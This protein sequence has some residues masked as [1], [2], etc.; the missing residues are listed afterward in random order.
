MPGRTLGENN[1]PKE[2]EPVA[3]RGERLGNVGKKVAPVL[4]VAT[5]VLGVFVLCTKHKKIL[6]MCRGR[7]EVA[8]D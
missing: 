6:Q 1:V 3:S 2:E 4:G 5:L 7:N 8:A